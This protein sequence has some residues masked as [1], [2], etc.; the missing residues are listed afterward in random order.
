MLDSWLLLADLNMESQFEP[1]NDQNHVFCILDPEAKLPAA[2]DKTYTTH[3]FLQTITS[4]LKSSVFG[5]SF[6]FWTK[7][8]VRCSLLKIGASKW[9]AGKIR[10]KI[11]LEFVPDEP[12]NS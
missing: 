3:D 4:F 2:G 12:N 6:D 5:S 8:G 10:V 9:V 7:T 1:L 11:T